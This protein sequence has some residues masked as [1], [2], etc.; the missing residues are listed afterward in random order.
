M[1]KNRLLLGVSG[2]LGIVLVLFL[3]ITRWLQKPE[4]IRHFEEEV[5]RPGQPYLEPESVIDGLAVYRVGEG[6]PVLLMP[7]PHGHTVEPMAQT[8]LADL[9]VS[10]GREVISFDVP[11]AYRSTRD[12]DGSM[13]EM[14]AAADE[15]LDRLGIKDPVDVVGHSMSGFVALAYAVER[16]ARVRSLVLAGSV[17]GFPAAARCGYPGSAFRI[18]EPDFWRIIIWGIR[19]N[20]GRESL[21]VHKKL[22]NL[23]QEKAFHDPSHFQPLEIHPEDYAKGVPVRM[24]WSKNMYQSLSYADRLK[25]VDADTL[26][27]AGRHDPEAGMGCAEELAT[28]IRKARFV[29]FEESGHAAFIEEPEKFAETLRSFFE[30][31][32][33]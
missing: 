12:P 4:Y 20:G 27:I 17:S 5:Y 14:L 30:E 31:I 26:V 33:Q 22:A 25:E 23:M 32:V 15:A 1:K 24:I 21:A 8:P 10:L 13:Q 19:V 16:P 29:V 28:G 3:Y 18:S 2:F 7:Y 6:P 11:G 9:L